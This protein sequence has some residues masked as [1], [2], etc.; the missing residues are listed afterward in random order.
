MDVKIVLKG[1][2]VDTHINIQ[3]I[4]EIPELN[5]LFVGTGADITRYN[6]NDVDTFS[7][8]ISNTLKSDSSI[9]TLEKL[10]KNISSI[11]DSI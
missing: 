9:A 1:G 11:W 3:A 8:V 5:E 7:G 10:T 2:G 4:I 6:L